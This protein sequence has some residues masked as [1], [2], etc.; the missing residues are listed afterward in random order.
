MFVVFV[1]N[2]DDVRDGYPIQEEK[3]SEYSSKT[4]K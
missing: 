2:N 3:K 4:I 1:N